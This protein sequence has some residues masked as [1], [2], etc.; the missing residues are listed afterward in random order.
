[1]I[2]LRRVVHAEQLIH[3]HGHLAW[4]IM[5]SSFGEMCK[6][7]R[8]RISCGTYEFPNFFDGNKLVSTTYIVRHACDLSH[9]T[10]RYCAYTI[11]HIEDKNLPW[12]YIKI[13]KVPLEIS[14]RNEMHNEANQYEK[15]L[16]AMSTT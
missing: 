2:D 10:M 4:H 16:V 7:E 6:G 8:G 13:Y 15:L 11:I 5:S 3:F 1:M 12:K 9:V 14:D